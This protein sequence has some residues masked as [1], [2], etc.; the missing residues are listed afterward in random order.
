M[1]YVWNVMKAN[2]GKRNVNDN[3]NKWMKENIWIM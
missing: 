3:K 1:K 2:G